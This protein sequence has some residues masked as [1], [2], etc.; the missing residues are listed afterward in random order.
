MNDQLHQ[1]DQYWMRHAL[2]LAHQAERMG[3]IPVGA[4]VVS[5]GK[6][7]GEGFNVPI[8][9]H[10]PRAHAEMVAIRQAAKHIENYRISNSTLYVTLEPCPMCSGAIVHSRINRVVFGAY[11]YK[12]GAAG[13]V[14]QLLDHEAL[15]HRVSITG[16]VLAGECA[17]RISTF[18]KRRRAQKKRE[19]KAR[20][21]LMASSLSPTE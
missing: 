18:F 3:E 11:D 1:T 6:I 2:A 5:E 16:G 7:I 17:A 21:A 19:K 13:S 15:N 14:L 10:D 4:I 12:T 20:K 9:Q 8:S